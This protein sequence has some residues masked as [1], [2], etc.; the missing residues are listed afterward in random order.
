MYKRSHLHIET[1]SICFVLNGRIYLQVR[2]VSFSDLCTRIW[3]TGS[4]HTA[5]CTSLYTRSLDSHKK[6]VGGI[7]G[8]FIARRCKYSSK[9]ELGYTSS[10]FVGDFTT[11]NN[12]NSLSQQLPGRLK[13]Y[14]SIRMEGSVMGQ[15]APLVFKRTCDFVQKMER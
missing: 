12:E 10:A 9:C 3:L 15:C 1:F 8:C 6:R 7:Y 4:N 5:R 14:V 13:K 2:G 11:S